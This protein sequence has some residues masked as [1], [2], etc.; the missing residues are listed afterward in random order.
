M[1]NK[2]IISP[3]LYHQQQ[4]LVSLST[5]PIIVTKTA[6]TLDSKSNS[7]SH[8]AFPYLFTTGPQSHTPKPDYHSK[9]LYFSFCLFPLL[10]CAFV[11]RQGFRSFY[12]GG[13]CFWN[14][15]EQLKLGSYDGFP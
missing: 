2:K 6:L 13:A 11:S 1:V 10:P 12:I 7:F 3:L 9:V 15:I 4:H 14:C 8:F 5:I